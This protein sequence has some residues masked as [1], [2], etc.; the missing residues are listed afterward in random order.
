MDETEGNSRRRRKTLNDVAARAGVSPVT[1]SR[2]LRRPEMV[3][4][5]LRQ[6]I[7]SAVQELAYIPNQL[8]SG[9]ASARTGTIGVLV[10][11][12]TNGV[13]ADYLRALHDAFL[14][15]GFQL[16]LLN[17][18]YLPE[19]EERGIATLL[20]QHPEAI[21]IAGVDQTARSRRLLQN[22]GVP[23]IQTMELTDNPLDVN[24]GFSQI[25]AGKAATRHLLALG[26]RRVG[27]IAARLDARARRRKE[28][29]SAAMMEAGLDGNSMLATT[30][31]PSSVRLGAELFAEVI[32][33]TPDLE[34]MF[35]CNDDLALGAL[36]ECQRRGIR[37]PDDI[38]IVGFN[39]LEFCAST[40]PTLTSVATPRHEMARRAAEIVIEVIRGSGNRPDNRRIDLGFTVNQRQSTRQSAAAPVRAAATANRS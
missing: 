8:A 16:L 29:Y 21:I 36:F 39:D 7:E 32:E 24:I 2:A 12:L 27:H 30:L 17:S 33:R 20:S 13:F 35:C 37:V 14:P 18:R 40:F 4:V 38:S 10:P 3:S 11:S 28:G 9:L 1:V 22:A 25:E 31:R 26:H 34:A 5:D 15:A 19:E 23:V 6:R